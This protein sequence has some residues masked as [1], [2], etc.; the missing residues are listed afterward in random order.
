MIADGGSSTISD[1]YQT[2]R[3]KKQR[4][5]LSSA[6][7]ELELEQ[8]ERKRDLKSKQKESIRKLYGR[9]NGKESSGKVIKKK[10]T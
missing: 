8:I 10:P 9:V 4:D 3:D 5:M 1:R 7:E 6:S 2:F